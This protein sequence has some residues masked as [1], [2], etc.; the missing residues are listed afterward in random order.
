MTSHGSSSSRGTVPYPR[1]P[2]LLGGI[3]LVLYLVTLCRSAG[4]GGIALISKVTGWDWQPLVDYPLYYLVSFPFRVLPL[5]WEPLAL[6]ALSALLAAG[7][8]ALV[9]RSV[10]LLPQNRTR[11]QRER[12]RN[13]FGL[14]T[15]SSA[16]LPA[17]V[18]ASVCGLQVAFWQN[19]TNA[20]ADMLNLF[21]LAWIVREFLEYRI[22]HRESRLT[23]LALIYGFGVT[24]N[25]ALIAL[26]PFMLGAIIWAMGWN[27]FRSPLILKLS[28]AGIAGLMLYLLLPAVATASG[29]MDLSFGDAL[30]ANLRDQKAMLQSGFTQ[31]LYVIVNMGIGSFLPLILIGVRWPASFGDVSAAGSFTTRVMFHV[32]TLLF[33]AG[34]LAMNLHLPH[35]AKAQ[36]ETGIT[37]HSLFLISALVLGYSVGYLLVVFGKQPAKAWKKPGP[38]GEFLGKVMVGVAW[39]ILPTVTVMLGT[40]NFPKVRGLNAS[41]LYDFAAR[42]A[43]QLPT[44]PALV[45]ADDDTL[46]SLVADQLARSGK[47]QYW[48]LHTRSL[49]DPGYH[50]I[51]RK[52]TGGEWPQLPTNMVVDQK[53]V[54]PYI[55]QTIA[56]LATNRPLIYLHPSFG[57]YFE[58]FYPV[59]DKFLYD[60]KRYT[61]NSGVQVPIATDAQI[62]VHQKFLEGWWDETLSSLSDRID[63]GKASIADSYLGQ[64]ESRALNDWGTRLEQASHFT[65]ATPWFERATHLFTNNVSALINLEY[66]RHHLA[67][68]TNAFKLS[69]STQAIWNNY[70]DNIQAALNFGGPI[71]EP[72]FC[73]GLGSLFSSTGLA[74]QSAQEFLQALALTPNN[75]FARIQLAR[76]FIQG[77]APDRALAVLDEIREKASPEGLNQYAQ[78]D[79]A[80]V[81]AVALLEKGEKD[82]AIA[83]LGELATKF[84]SEPAVYEVQ[85]QIYLNAAARQPDFLPLAEKSVKRLFDLSPTNFVAINDMGTIEMFKQNWPGAINYLTEALAKKPDA[86]ET[87]LNRAI[88]FL[89]AGQLGQALEDYL[90][91]DKKAPNEFRIE[92]GLAEIAEKQKR[93]ADAI[94]Y[95]G[96]YLS[97]APKGTPEYTN[98]VDRLIQLRGK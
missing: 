48:L 93:T 19:A 44:V 86:V 65:E 81:E 62:Q 46:L 92:Y 22:D 75:Q 28:I 76:T 12:E 69:D 1:L 63:S 21:I 80:N 59:E 9:T 24:S 17:A 91:L 50:V 70:R 66:N 38:L 5:A 47:K 4:V 45:L 41:P 26:F 90:A 78:I 71:E 11:D 43:Q 40:Q 57:Y 85:S 98:V 13:E 97:H 33:I 51:L 42:M 83:R 60:L 94:K 18:A 7:T 6:N 14:L 30:L 73:I 96:E 15:G 53:V 2:W 49:S 67:G 77:Q 95:F 34:S 31:R 20:S 54:D 79:L 88:A 74:R 29:K 8:V 64:I 36:A 72:S 16:W 82:K 35:V 52:L 87:R 84:P 3:F 56:T 27:F 39:L 37:F 55:V 32:L 10:Q 89:R 25:C 61:T 68:D 58:W 23:L